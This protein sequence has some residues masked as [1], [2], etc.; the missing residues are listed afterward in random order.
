[1]QRI[2]NKKVA[3]FKVSYSASGNQYIT[4][5]FTD[6]GYGELSCRL[7]LTDTWLARTTAFLKRL[8][9]PAGV[10]LAELVDASKEADVSRLFPN[11]VDIVVALKEFR[12]GCHYEVVNILD[13]TSGTAASTT[14]AKFEALMA[15][16]KDE[17]SASVPASRAEARAA[18]ASNPGKSES[19]TTRA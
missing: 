2:H 7:M 16:A 6:P 19:R 5:G 15:S 11:E 18:S 1:M 9:L 13:S 4:V 12:G 3:S 8:G 14:A 10:K 17:S